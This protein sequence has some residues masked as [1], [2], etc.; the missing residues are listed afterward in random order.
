MPRAGRRTA[1]PLILLVFS[2][3][4]FLKKILDKVS[5]IDIIDF[6]SLDRALA[7]RRPF[8]KAAAAVLRKRF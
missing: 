6:A 1:Q 2:R 4:I 5:R 3:K 7:E 8:Q